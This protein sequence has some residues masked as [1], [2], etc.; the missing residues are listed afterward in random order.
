MES[1]KTRSR[2]DSEVGKHEDDM[3]PHHAMNLEMDLSAGDTGGARK[4][5]P[6]FEMVLDDVNEGQVEP[7]NAEVTEDDGEVDEDQPEEAGPVIAEVLDA[8]G[9]QVDLSK[10]NDPESADGEDCQ[11][12]VD[13]EAAKNNEFTEAIGRAV[14]EAMKE[15]NRFTSVSSDDGHRNIS[16]QGVVV[17]EVDGP[18]SGEVLGIKRPARTG[19][20]PAG[21]EVVE[22]VDHTGSEVFISGWDAIPRERQ[23]TTT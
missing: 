8:N 5:V 2:K 1:R 11:A 4:A 9:N 10:A 14:K 6:K 17:E 18:G 13:N 19:A 7:I 15:F 3:D 22:R 20:H 21:N 12:S 23:R 16:Q